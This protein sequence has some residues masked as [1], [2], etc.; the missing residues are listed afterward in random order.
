MIHFVIISVSN[1]TE[2]TLN[3]NKCLTDIYT[4]TQMN[5]V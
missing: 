2:I 5:P 4:H 1:C 3:I